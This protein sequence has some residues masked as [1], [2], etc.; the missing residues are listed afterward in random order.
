MGQALVSN[1]LDG[2]LPG[3][4]T[5]ADERPQEQDFPIGMTGEETGASP[6]ALGIEAVKKDVVFENDDP[7]RPR[8]QAFPQAGHVG[9]VGALFDINGMTFHDDEFDF[10]VQP[11]SGELGGCRLPSIF[12]L[13]QGDAIDAIKKIPAVGWILRGCICINRFHHCPRLNRPYIAARV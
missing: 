12:A 7:L 10:A 4:S 3:F 9:F 6:E 11:D 8:F 5:G 2:G 1:L 13:F